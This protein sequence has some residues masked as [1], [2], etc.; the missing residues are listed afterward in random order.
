MDNVFLSYRRKSGSELASV[1][2]HMLTNAGYSVFFDVKSLRAGDFETR[3]D[4]EIDRCTFFLVL[5][6]PH[7]LDRSLKSPE[8]DWIVH[9]VDRA[10]KRGKIIIPV[11][12]KGFKFPKN[13]DQ[14]TIK[15]LSQKYIC[16]LSGT[17]FFNLITARLICEFFKD[18]PAKELSKEFNE[19]IV[20]LNFI[21]WELETLKGIYHDIPF[22]NTFGQEFPVFTLPGSPK[23]VFPFD[24]LTKE[25]SL[26]AVE[27]KLNYEA[28]PW[29]RDFNK[30]VGPHIHFP[31]LLGYTSVGYDFDEQGRIEGIRAIPRTYNETAY[32]TNILQ[33][34]LWRVYKKIGKDRFATLDDLPM[35]KA[36][37]GNKSN[38]E[39]ILS[40][41]N[42]SA[43][44]DVTIA[45][46]A[47]N[48]ITSEYEIA[49][50][51]RS[52]DVAIYPGYYS[53]IPSGGFELYELEENQDFTVIKANYSVIGALYRE[54]LE[55]LFGDERFSKPTGDDDLNR[56]YRNSKIQYLRD[57]VESGILN[58]EFLGV[59]F[60]L[61]SLRQTLAFVLRIDDKKFFYNNEIK[62]NS[63]S[64]SLKFQV[65]S[66]IEENI[67]NS[68]LPV[69]AETAATYSLL[70][71]N[72]LYCEIAK[73]NFK[74]I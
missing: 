16:D 20:D 63:E 65:L 15:V 13:C 74:K 37:H 34:E 31:E 30:I 6:A 53:F 24:S 3:I 4:Q 73:N 10:I 54:Y 60:D 25:E 49:S 58:F 11:G 14:E 45:V 43:L 7:D 2:Y 66:G 55:E 42:R 21:K 18:N 70:M 9:E 39:V 71:H 17:E 32:T 36:I 50:A 1:L 5:L 48:V 19:G 56:L 8:T 12:I 51:V 62:K 35:R 68:K 47:I 44:Y 59:N 38:R 27:E 61:I 67:R 52:A 72:H 69:M 57:G 40:G 26:Q 22:V 41:C 33:Y 64:K 28:S 23:V 46:M 29:F